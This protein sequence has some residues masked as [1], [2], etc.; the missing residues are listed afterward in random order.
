MVFVMYWREIPKSFEMEYDLTIRKG[1][2]AFS[3]IWKNKN[4]IKRT[5][6]TFLL[7][8]SSKIL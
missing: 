2:S 8:N 4:D 3:Y 1:F 6:S 7:P 5:I